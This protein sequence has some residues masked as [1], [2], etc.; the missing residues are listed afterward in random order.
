MARR[1]TWIVLL[2][3][4]LVALLSPVHNLLQS[5]ETTNPFTDTECQLAAMAVVGGLFLIVALARIGC[6]L[7]KFLRVDILRLCLA[8][9]AIGLMPVQ[10]ACTTRP[11]PL[12]SSLRI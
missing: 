4:F 9:Q 3:V 5:G 12:L 10:F 2:V 11:P 6:F 7:L 8:A 1:S